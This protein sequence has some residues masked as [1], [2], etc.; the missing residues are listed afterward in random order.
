MH[1]VRESVCSWL[2]SSLA[3]ALPPS[4]DVSRVLLRSSFSACNAFLSLSPSLHKLFDVS[5]IHRPNAT[6][7]VCALPAVSHP[8]RV[9]SALISYDAS[10]FGGEEAGKPV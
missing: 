10:E 2:P 8:Y 1:G 9:K 4:L 7:Q 6:E 3:A 5:E